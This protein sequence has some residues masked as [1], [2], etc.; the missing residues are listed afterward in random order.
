MKHRLLEEDTMTY[1]GHKV[2]RIQYLEDS[3]FFDAGCLGG[4]VEKGMYLHDCLILGNSK[5]VKSNI[6]DNSVIIDSYV[7][8]SN[9]DGNSIIRNSNVDCCTV[10]NST[11]T[12]TKVTDSVVYS[13]S[14]NTCTASNLSI[15]LV[16]AYNLYLN[17]LRIHAKS[18]VSIDKISD[19][20]QFK[21]WWSSGR[22]FCYIPANK[23]WYVGCFQGTHDELIA[24]AYQDSKDSGDHYKAIVDLVKSM[25][26]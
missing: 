20:L 10:K 13:S 23:T 14:I 16:N 4:Y 5:V 2:Y 19:F 18:L 24:K 26:L 17:N 1:L 21:N 15:N 22:Y 9:I 8:Y 11:I 12:S 3:E 6:T 7:S 25:G